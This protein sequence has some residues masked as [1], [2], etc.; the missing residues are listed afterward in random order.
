MKNEILYVENLTTDL[1]TVRNIDHISFPLNNG[2]ILGITGLQHSGIAAL[3][4]AL[5]G[6]LRPSNGTIYLDGKPVSLTSCSHANALGIYEIKHS[7]SVISTLSVSENLNVLRN[8][9]WKNFFI[10]KKLNLENT[11]AIFSHYGISIDPDTLTSDLTIGQQVELAICRA[12]LCGARILVCWEIGEGLSA[13]E[14]AEVY[15]F[16]RQLR[17]EG[18]PI[19][20]LNSD[21]RK[22][23]HIADRIIVL[24]NGMLCYHRRTDELSAEE[25]FRCITPDTVNMAPP[26]PAPPQEPY[27][28]FHRLHLS[29]TPDQWDFS[30]KMYPGAIYGL[31]WKSAIRDYMVYSIFTG[32]ITAIG[33]VTENGETISFRKWQQ[34]NRRNIRCLGI[35]FWESDLQENLTLAENL[36]LFSY[37]R[38]RRRGGLLNRRMLRLA[39]LD[40]AREQGIPTEYLSQY[41]RHLPPEIRNQIVLWGLLFAPPKY[42]IL[43]CPMYAMDEQ[44]RRYC[45]RALSELRQT[46]TAILWSSN[47]EVFLRK[48]SDYLS[49]VQPTF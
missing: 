43:D 40:F 48:H 36:C 15:H 28:I 11:R 19:I 32:Q 9:S 38:F 49:I 3:A 2:E 5:S 24:R 30:A 27:V 42:L 44:V 4:D 18:V 8:F 45:L 37:S 29:N 47:N 22:I 25:V 17:E 14:F 20:M 12:L 13:E 16:L 31:L 46:Q 23:M 35:R 1:K 7:L 21:P 39:L 26:S 10:N 6:N 41:P 34:K 33:S